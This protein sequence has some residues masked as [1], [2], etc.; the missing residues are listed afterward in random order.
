MSLVRLDDF[1]LF[2]YPLFL[3]LRESSSNRL[4]IFCIVAQRDVPCSLLW[5]SSQVVSNPGQEMGSNLQL[6]S[7]SHPV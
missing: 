5:S 6:V 2:F 1:F 3:F 4:I 7:T